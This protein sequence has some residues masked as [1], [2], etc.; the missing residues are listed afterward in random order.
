MAVTRGKICVAD[1][2]PVVLRGLDRALRRRG[3]AVRTAGSGAELLS[4]VEAERPD[5]VILDVG[6]PGM[7]GLEVLREVHT[8]ERWPGLPVLLITALGDEAVT[9]TADV[10]DATAVLYKPFHLADLFGRVE[11]CLSAGAQDPSRRSRSSHS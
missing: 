7:D 8:A 5:L 9:K 3:Y 2:D 11:R 4:L 1:D 6:M 10:G